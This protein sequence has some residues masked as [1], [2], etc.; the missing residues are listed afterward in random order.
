MEVGRVWPSYNR[1]A[2]AECTK[3]NQCGSCWPGDCFSIANY[4][5]YKV[6]DYGEVHG[7]DKMKAEIYHN[8]PIACGIAATKKFETYAGG[9]YT[10]ETDEGIDHIIS[11]RPCRSIPN[12]L[13]LKVVGWGVDHDSGVPYWIG[14]NSWGKK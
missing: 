2:S 6:G 3:Y 14:R 7:I 4:T 11:V 5:L 12:D 13:T 10:E 8:G 9:I 1:C